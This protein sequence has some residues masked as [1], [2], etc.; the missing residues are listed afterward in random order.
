M[1]GLS[2]FQGI[3]KQVD[4]LHRNTPNEVPILLINEG[5]VCPHTSIGAVP[6]FDNLLI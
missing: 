4:L 3:R 5:L 6:G 1:G 2:L